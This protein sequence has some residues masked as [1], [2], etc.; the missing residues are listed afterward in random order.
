MW[1]VPESTTWC[2]ALLAE[3]RAGTTAEYAG[4]ENAVTAEGLLDPSSTGK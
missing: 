2:P 3:S 1:F 4:F